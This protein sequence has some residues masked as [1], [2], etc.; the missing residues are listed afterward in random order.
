MGH[1]E[2]IGLRAHGAAALIDLSCHLVKSHKYTGNA[3][4]VPGPYRRATHVHAHPCTCMYGTCAHAGTHPSTPM[5]THAP[6]PALPSP[7]RGRRC[8]GG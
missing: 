5:R 1:V 4:A 8:G 7:P 2:E 6:I 3:L